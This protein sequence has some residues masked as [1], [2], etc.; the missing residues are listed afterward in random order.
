[1]ELAKAFSALDIKPERSVIFLSPTGE[2][3]GLLGSEYYATHPI[4]PLNKTAGAINMDGL[5]NLGPTKDIA[6]I[7]LGR[8]E[9]DNYITTVAQRQ[10][11]SVV[12][13]FWSEFGAYYRSDHFPLAKQGLPSVFITTGTEHLEKGAEWMKKQGVNDNII[14]L[15]R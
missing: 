7:G 15:A 5:N 3:Y 6:V 2:E 9:L 1:M 10:N 12:K 13:S 8:S 11:R 14:W 4:Y